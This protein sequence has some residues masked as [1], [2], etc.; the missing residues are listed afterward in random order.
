MQSTT[1]AAILANLAG[2]E[3]AAALSLDPEVEDVARPQ[4]AALIPEL[5]LESPLRDAE[6]EALPEAERL[7]RV[8]PRPALMGDR[9]R[10][11]AGTITPRAR[12]RHPHLGGG[13]RALAVHVQRQVARAVCD[14]L[15]LSIPAPDTHRSIRIG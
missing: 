2:P 1:T 14:L 7:A 8:R 6:L 15:W 10:P 9:H 3:T 5:A 12:R 4:D 11:A 13:L